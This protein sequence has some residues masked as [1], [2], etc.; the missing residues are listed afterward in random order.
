MRVDRVHALLREA[1]LAKDRPQPVLGQ[2]VLDQPAWQHGHAG[3]GHGEGTQAAGTIHAHHRIA[4]IGGEQRVAAIGGN[5]R[6]VGQ[7]W[8]AQ[9][10]QGT[11][12]HGVI[13][14]IGR[15][16]ACQQG[17]SRHRA[18]WMAFQLAGMQP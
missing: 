15:G 11:Q 8:V 17:R 1:V 13:G 10:G 12:L 4:G 5:H 6:H 14:R 9:A 16:Q 2:V 7:A 18:Q 3:A